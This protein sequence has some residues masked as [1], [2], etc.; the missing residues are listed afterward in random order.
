MKLL[1]KENPTHQELE[2]YYL[3]LKRQQFGG[4]EKD[5]VLSDNNGSSSYLWVNKERNLYIQQRFHPMDECESFKI[6]IKYKNDDNGYGFFYCQTFIYSPKSYSVYKFETPY[7]HVCRMKDGSI[8]SNYSL[9]Q[10]SFKEFE[11]K[12]KPI[13]KALYENSPFGRKEVFTNKILRL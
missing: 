6:F 8:V 2:D 4:Y 10:L 7:A 13:A 11:K 3:M 9:K 5:K 12:L 1:I